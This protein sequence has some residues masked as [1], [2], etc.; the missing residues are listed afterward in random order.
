MKQKTGSRPE[1]H[2]EL[3][4]W[5]LLAARW[6]LLAAMII[7]GYLLYVSLSSGGAAGCGPDSGCDRVLKSRWAFWF[8]VP[9][10]GLALPVYLGLLALVSGLGPKSRPA[11]RRR[12]W[13]FAVALGVMVAGAA[14]WFLGL[15]AFAINGLC[16]FCL[17]AHLCGLSAA[18]LLLFS[19]PIRPSP[20]LPWQ[21]EKQVYLPPP[22]AKKFALAGCAGL[23]V[24]LAG[25]A[26][27]Q[28]KTHL[29]KNLPSPG[30][31]MGSGS[32]RAVASVAPPVTPDPA[33]AAVP[34]PANKASPAKT[35]LASPLPPPSA[36]RRVHT[37][38]GGLFQFDLNELPLAGR[39]EASKVMV[40]LFDYTCHH[41]Q[42]MHGHLRTAREYFSN[43][44]A[45]ISLPMPLDADC[46]PAVT[47]TH[48]T[49]SNACQYARL[50]LA[51]WRADR[52][53]FEEFDDWLFAKPRPP[54]LE[55]AR[56]NAVRLVGAAALEKSLQDPWINQQ[57]QTSIALY[58]T[59]LLALRTG[60]MPQLILGS[61]VS[62][63]S[64]RSAEDLIKLI[65]DNLPGGR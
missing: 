62:V 6:L 29:V 27:H 8:G 44:L 50:G 31:I 36:A 52:R 42:I 34:P 41:C 13:P 25:Q 46:N 59:N 35:N 12:L 26:L 48:H 33:P 24:L 64:M 65:L 45:I 55:E 49:A 51:V 30:G 57:L 5:R 56:S 17:A 20:E 19:A 21:R 7:A 60:Q 63:G 16:P 9:V 28:K 37:T 18:L 15:M 1:S 58:Q 39:P 40:S 61:R 53:H 10:S 54:S 47:R 2:L 3:P 38:H 43:D 4:P 23:V 22:T 14:L 32:N 11:T